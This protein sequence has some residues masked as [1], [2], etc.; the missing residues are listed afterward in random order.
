VAETLE[1][2]SNCEIVWKRLLKNVEEGL[3]IVSCGCRGW[4]RD[5]PPAGEQLVGGAIEPLF[6]ALPVVQVSDQLTGQAIDVD[7]F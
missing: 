7:P 1:R 3:P 5:L 2:V 4:S 6:G